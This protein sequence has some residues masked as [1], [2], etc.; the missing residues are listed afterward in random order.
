MVLG[1]ERADAMNWLRPIPT[2]T[3]CGQV[4]AHASRHPEIMSLQNVNCCNPSGQ[5]VCNIEGWP[6]LKAN[7]F[8]ATQQV[9]PPPFNKIK[10]EI[11]CRKRPILFTWVDIFTGHAHMMVVVGYR[12]DANGTQDVEI[13]DPQRNR[14]LPLSY[15][16]FA[17]PRP[18]R[19]FGD[20]IY[21][22]VDKNP[23]QVT[24]K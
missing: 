1:R 20:A 3:Q 13:Y 12:S 14:I 2:I 5:S 11:S 22:I 15:A 10:D 9:G 8:D 19:S 23:T 18:F 17:D 7:G 21:G 4:N 6:E 24:T 16:H